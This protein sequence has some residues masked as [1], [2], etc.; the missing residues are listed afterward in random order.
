MFL[1][2]LPF[3]L[4]MTIDSVIIIDSTSPGSIEDLSISLIYYDFVTDG[5]WVADRHAWELML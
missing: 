3:A 1:D 2:D 5:I 4:S